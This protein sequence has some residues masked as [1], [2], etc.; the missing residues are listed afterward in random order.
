M[1]VCVFINLKLN[2]FFLK[3][4]LIEKIQNHTLELFHFI[5]R[6]ILVSMMIS[7]VDLFLYFSVSKLTLDMIIGTCL[8]LFVFQVNG[9]L[10][11]GSQIAYNCGVKEAYYM[12]NAW[13]KRPGAKP[14]LPDL[15]EFTPDL[16]R[17]FDVFQICFGDANT[18]TQHGCTLA[19]SVPDHRI[20]FQRGGVRQGLQLSAGFQNEPS[21]QMSCVV[22]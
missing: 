14:K 1:C 20:I 6:Y 3:K 5:L 17:E 4:H 16:Q 18:T 2:R 15:Q 9:I 12:Q 13:T 8:T 10:T 22:G 19:R 21:E 11:L 7:K